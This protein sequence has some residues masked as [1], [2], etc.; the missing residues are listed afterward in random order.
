[1]RIHKPLLAFFHLGKQWI[2]VTSTSWS[3][4]VNEYKNHSG[5]MGNNGPNDL[6]LFR[7][8]IHSLIRSPRPV[9]VWLSLLPNIYSSNEISR[10]SSPLELNKLKSTVFVIRL[11]EEEI[12]SCSSLILHFP[13]LSSPEPT[14]ASITRQDKT[15]LSRDGMLKVKVSSHTGLRSPDLVEVFWYP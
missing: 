8:T 14:S 12:S 6:R 2:H 15:M 11:G 7:V 5:Y 13:A 4:S 3:S 1:M 9:L 10:T